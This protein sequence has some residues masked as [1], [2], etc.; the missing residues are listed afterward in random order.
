MD[1][2]LHHD[3]V[4]DQTEHAEG[5]EHQPECEHHQQCGPQWAVDV[6]VPAV[7]VPSSQVRDHVTD[8]LQVQTERDRD[9]ESHAE[10]CIH[11]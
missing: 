6:A 2:N 9:T 3:L 4:P 1:K 7:Q 8:G 11:T 5:H 10:T